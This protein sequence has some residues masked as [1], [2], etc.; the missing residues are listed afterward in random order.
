MMDDALFPALQKV[1][2]VAAATPVVEGFVTLPDYPG[3]YLRILGVDPLT[4]GP[5]ENAKIE[6]LNRESLNSSAWFSNPAA[7]AVTSQFAVAHHLKRGDAI[8]IMVN[9]R[10]V[11]LVLSF[12]L[13]AKDG[14][15]RFAVMDIGWA[16]EL[17]QLQGKL[18]TVLFR[19][20]GP[21]HPGPVRERLQRLLPPDILV[22]APERR[23]KQV[24]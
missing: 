14:E 12:I 7:V 18:T 19:V 6:D 15:N 5:F 16:Q 13:Q 4:N 20:R 3:E 2:G 1:N 24:E 9:G 23:S 21:D 17:L 22:Q 10:E 8:R 11:R